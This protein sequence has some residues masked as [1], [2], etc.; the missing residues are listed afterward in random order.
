[1]S[2]MQP[3]RREL[4][5][6]LSPTVEALG[7][8]LW[9]LQYSANPKHS[10]LRI[11]IDKPDG[12]SIEDCERVSRQVSALLDV[13]DPVSGKYQ[14][15]VSSPGLDRPLFALDHFQRCVGSVVQVRLRQPFEGRRNYSGQ[16]VGVEDENVVIRVDDQEYVVPYEWIDR[17]Q[18]VP[19]FD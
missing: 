10:V 8:E 11:Y 15:E 1:M 14:L 18:V 16:L 2:G 5:A 12:V 19:Q 3:K 7:C 6:L 4:M 9:G 17:A 13:E